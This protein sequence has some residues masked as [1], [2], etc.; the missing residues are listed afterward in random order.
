M[1]SNTDCHVLEVGIFGQVS[2]GLGVLFVFCTVNSQRSSV[3]HTSSSDPCKAAL[4]YGY[5]ADLAH[6]AMVM[7][8]DVNDC[9]LECTHAQLL[10]A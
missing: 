9:C 3:V 10:C 6:H 1:R 2:L 5:V 7:L 8:D 4:W